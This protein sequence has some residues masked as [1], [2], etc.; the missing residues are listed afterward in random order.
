MRGVNVFCVSLASFLRSLGSD[1][2]STLGHYVLW[3]A[4]IHHR[5]VS[6]DNLM[7]YRVD[8]QVIGV[9]NDYDLASLASDTPLGNQRTGTMLFMA[10]DL[11]K[12][13]G[14]DGKVKHLY[15][16]DMES[17][18]W[19]FIWICHQFKDGRQRPRGPLDAWA[20]VDAQGCAKEKRSFLADTPEPRDV[21][22]RALVLRVSLFLNAR[23]HD[24]N[25]SKVELDL[26][27]TELQDSNLATAESGELTQQIRH[28]TRTLLN[29]L[30][31][32]YSQ[33]SQ[34]RFAWT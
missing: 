32:M 8:G 23:H 4:G 17:F 16:H 2:H 18:I 15:R 12:A 33:N 20:K 6:C 7:Y 27:K 26:A 25:Q 28:S 29:N 1:N 13:D 3:K 24:R 31:M 30:T 9:L 34:R 19:V 11:L 21:A 14:Q 10:I 22:H 5:D